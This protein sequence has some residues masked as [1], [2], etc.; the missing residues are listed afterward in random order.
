MSNDFK[1][2]VIHTQSGLEERAKNLL[3]EQAKKSGCADS[4][5]QIH[6]PKISVEKVTKDGN[7]KKR[8]KASYPGYILVEMNVNDQSRLVIRRTPKV[9]GFIGNSQ[10][11]LP[12]S[13]KEV[14]KLI[15]PELVEEQEVLE[16]VSDY[17]KGEI[18]KVKDG[19]FINFDGIVDEVKPDRLKLKILVSI[20]GR[21][22]PVELNFSQVERIE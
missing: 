12:L 19:P 13:E 1:W 10:N 8:I 5:G 6:I 11:P 16:I 20:F 17:K 2:Y 3:L 22:T 14:L 7:R 4:F 18:V 9:T 15:S 21:E